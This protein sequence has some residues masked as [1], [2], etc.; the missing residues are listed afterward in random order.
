MQTKEGLCE[1][2][3]LVMDDAL[4][5]GVIYAE[6]RFAPQLHTNKGMTQEQAVL[7]ALDGLKRFG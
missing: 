7:V 4:S 5:R 3:R 6:L 1:A 2:V